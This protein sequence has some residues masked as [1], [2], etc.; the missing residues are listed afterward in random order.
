MQLEQQLSQKQKLLLSQ[1]MHRSLL[2]LQMPATELCAWLREEA[3]SNPLLALDEAPINAMSAA[4]QPVELREQSLWSVAPVFDDERPEFVSTLS[5]PASFA[6]HL[7]SQLGE[8]RGL[9]EGLRALCLY[10]VGCLDSRGY[11]DCPLDEL[12]DELGCPLFDLE[13][14]LFAVQSLDPAGVGARDLSECLLL[15][16]ARGRDFN[17][18]NIRL[19]RAG[20]P[21][22]A[23]GDYAALAA[24]LGVKPA[25]A[26]RAGDVIRSLNPIPSA[27][28]SHGAATPYLV[29]EAVF[30]CEGERLIV[31]LNPTALPALHLDEEYTAMLARDDCAS[32]LPY[33]RERV[34]AANGVI[35]A[36]NDRSA[37]LLRVLREVASLQQNYFLH[38]AP[39]RPLTMQQLADRLD[40]SVS[41][42]SRAVKDKYIRC[43]TQLIPLRSLFTAALPTRQGSV[44][45]AAV[46]QRIAALVAAEDGAAPLSDAAL[47]DA[48]NGAG[49]R[50]SRRTVA[51]YRAELKLPPAASRR[52]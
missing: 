8:L 4:E 9:D 40:L 6:E 41:T 32:A 16:L 51:K 29:P 47:C 13:Q 18:V 44:S 35:A 49:I 10:L 43:E 26:R 42:V 33:L 12:A 2:C 24:L 17:A 22:L 31:E 23:E 45:P 20:L 46:R 21:L 50:I 48:L 19:I 1:S 5:R 11:L 34:A 36:V 3:L 27:G 30:R 38:A 25:Q 14:A 15:Q 28:F 39:L 52:Q 37:T 7:A